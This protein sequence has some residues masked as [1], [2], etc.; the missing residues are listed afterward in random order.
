MSET[1]YSGVY[2]PSAV[3]GNL[4][5]LV[6]L[7]QEAFANLPWGE[8]SKCAI[9]PEQQLAV[10][11]DGF[12]SLAIGQ[13]CGDCNLE[14]TEEAYPENELREKFTSDLGEDYR[15]WYLEK[16]GR[17]ST[18][19]LAT[20]AR[21]TTVNGLAEV[22]AE[23]SPQLSDWLKDKYEDDEKKIVWIEDVFA[24]VDIRPKGN[25]INF[26]SMVNKLA[27]GT[28][29]DEVAFST[30][31]P[32]LVRAA[33]RDFAGNVDISDPVFEEVPGRGKFV[34]IRLGSEQARKA[35]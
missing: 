26:G 14:I 4:D 13:T 30:L 25:L 32:K 9:Y 23:K 21:I 1:I 7:Y 29:S 12:S 19:V 33:Q 15:L 16:T 8:R 17:D 3:S 18:I 35:A 6:N 34:S 20:L 31:N 5:E 11:P 28:G 10:C 22:V 24:N 27:L 2:A